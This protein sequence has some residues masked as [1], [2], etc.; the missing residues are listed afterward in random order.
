MG[1]KASIGGGAR[2][3]QC[4]WVFWTLFST[5]FLS[6]SNLGRKLLPNTC[7][8]KLAYRLGKCMLGAE[9][10]PHRSFSCIFFLAETII[11]VP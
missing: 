7:F 9:K 1:V 3:K 10:D 2:G 6:I 4:L 11:E 8:L 5:P